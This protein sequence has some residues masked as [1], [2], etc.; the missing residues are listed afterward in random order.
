VELH[1]K[2]RVPQVGHYVVV[3]EY[4]TEADQLFVVDMNVKSP[5][6]VLDG[7]VNIYSCKYR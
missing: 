6:S 1:L 3:L 5:G 7:Q 2:L 4:A